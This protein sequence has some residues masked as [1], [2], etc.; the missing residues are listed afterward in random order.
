MRAVG[1]AT[2]L[3]HGSPKILQQHDLIL[4]FLED[5]RHLL[6][7]SSIKHGQHMSGWTQSRLI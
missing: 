2:S 7:A 1:I 3:A 4:L 5:T 6:P